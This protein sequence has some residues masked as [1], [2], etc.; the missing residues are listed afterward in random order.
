M[1]IVTEAK[2]PLFVYTSVR[3]YVSDFNEMEMRKKY[4]VKQMHLSLLDCLGDICFFCSNRN[5]ESQRNVK[6]GYTVAELPQI[7][8]VALEQKSIK[9]LKK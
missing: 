8:A 3:Y 9:S 1:R 7:E 6:N 2:R 5:V 4:C